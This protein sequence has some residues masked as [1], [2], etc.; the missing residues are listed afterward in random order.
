MTS[1]RAGTP[2]GPRLVG[3]ERE[4]AVIEAE[5]ARAVE[6]EFRCVLLLGDPGVGKTRLA[7]EILARFAQE[8]IT[9]LARAHP[10]GGTTSLGLWAEAFEGHLRA[11]DPTEVSELC[12][13][14]LDDLAALLRSAAAARALP[15]AGEPPAPASSRA[16]PCC[17]PTWRRPPPC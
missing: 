4:L 11:V 2:R 15:P 3:R 1:G 9:L 7:S 13:G 6:G 12:G 16:W 14:F 17:W 8:A 10:L 5:L